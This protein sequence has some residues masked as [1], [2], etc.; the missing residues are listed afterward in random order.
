MISRTGLGLVPITPSFFIRFQKQSTLLRRRSRLICRAPTVIVLS[1][2][3][4]PLR[5]TLHIAV[6]EEYNL[7][8]EQGRLSRQELLYIS[9]V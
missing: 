9:C 3:L 2:S 4:A 8:A 5:L 1:D 7:Q 6:E